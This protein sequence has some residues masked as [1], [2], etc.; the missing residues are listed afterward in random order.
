[1]SLIIAQG[2]LIKRTYIIWVSMCSSQCSLSGWTQ[3]QTHVN[4]ILWGVT[5]KPGCCWT[6][7]LSF[8][9]SRH[10]SVWCYE[11]EA[12]PGDPQQSVREESADRSHP[13]RRQRW[14][15]S[16]S[17]PPVGEGSRWVYNTD[18]NICSALV[19]TALGIPHLPPAAKCCTL[20]Q[21]LTLVDAD[22]THSDHSVIHTWTHGGASQRQP[23]TTSSPLPTADKYLL[24]EASEEN[25]VSSGSFV[26]IIIELQRLID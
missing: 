14:P 22:E 24:I 19:I 11:G 4:D 20:S 15:R 16:R 6:C 2:G 7:D 21:M 5:V 17:Q 26:V 3:F 10:G 13:A 25:N 18:L 12:G 9:V 1:M 8:L 23:L